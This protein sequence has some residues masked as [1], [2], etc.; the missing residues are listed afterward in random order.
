[1]THLAARLCV[2]SIFKMFSFVWGVQTENEVMAAIKTLAVRQE[3]T[4]VARVALHNMKQD[5]DETVRS[6][7][8]RLRG[9]ASVC[10]F[11]IKCSGC[12]NDVNYT[13]AILRDVVTKGIADPEIQLDLLGDKNQDMPLEDILKFVEA[14]ESGKRSASKLLDSNAVEAASSSYKR[15]KSGKSSAASHDRHDFS[16]ARNKDKSDTCGYCGKRGHGKS[17]P[18]R[19]RR[20]ECLAY[21]HVC[22][23]CNRSHHMEAV[24]RSKDKPKAQRSD[25]VP[26]SAAVFDALCNINDHVTAFDNSCTVN[27][28]NF[29][30]SV[31]IDHHVYDKLSDTWVRQKSKTQPFIN[32]VARVSPEDYSALGF[33]LNQKKNYLSG[34]LCYG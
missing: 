25:I 11:I 22:G 17:A 14:K 8:V 31:C 15:D 13:D 30:H 1:M 2:I 34:I 12:S 9:Q 5:R 20:N 7:G 6:F 29:E 23:L 10:K 33:R 28:S 32:V 21:G 27:D 19:I 26:S 16:T 3:N 4:M 24:C 18:S